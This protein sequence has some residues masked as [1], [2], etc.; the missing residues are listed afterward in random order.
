[1]KQY[2]NEESDE[3]GPKMYQ[4]NLQRTKSV[5]G[6]SRH[7]IKVPQNILQQALMLEFLKSD[8]ILKTGKW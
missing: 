1:M 3:G 2:G 7:K 8:E 6:R 5:E 4:A